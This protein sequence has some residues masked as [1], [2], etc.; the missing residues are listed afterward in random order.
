MKKIL[1]LMCFFLLTGSLFSGSFIY[2]QTTQGSNQTE[3]AKQP[4][5]FQ[6]SSPKK[7]INTMRPDSVFTKGMASLED[8][9]YSKYRNTALAAT[10]QSVKAATATL[11]GFNLINVNTVPVYVKFYNALAADVIEVWRPS[12]RSQVQTRLRHRQ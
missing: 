5:Q 12:P 7:P 11:W 10:K 1:I 6:T 8:P 2:A 9:G 4:Q 3:E